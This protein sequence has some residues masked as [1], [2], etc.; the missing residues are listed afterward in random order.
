H[1]EDEIA[2]SEA[3]TGKRPFARWW[4]HVAPVRLDA[5]KMS[6]SDRNMVFVRDALGRASPQA[7]RLYLLDRHYRRR[8]DH[9]EA[10]L[11]RS[12]ERQ[13][14][15]A[16]RQ[17][18]LAERLGRRPVGPIGRDAG[19]RAVLAALDD[20]LD[21]ARAIRALERVSRTADDHAKASL[22]WIAH[23]VLGIVR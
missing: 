19:T 6:K 7:V 13:R 4:M 23:Q 14:R 10:W 8:F 5:K 1:H 18:A 3:A 22:R 20:D 21:T 12:A 15:L 16:E 9:D 11:A 17:A 2:Q